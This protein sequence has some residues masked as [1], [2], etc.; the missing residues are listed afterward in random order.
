MKWTGDG[1]RNGSGV[2]QVWRRSS[3]YV[4]LVGG[5]RPFPHAIV[6]R[7]RIVTG[8]CSTVRKYYGVQPG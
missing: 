3:G 7:K 1:L 5:E 6:S 2:V 8:R 4:A